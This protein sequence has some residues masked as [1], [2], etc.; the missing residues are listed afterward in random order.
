STNGTGTVRRYE[1]DYRSG[2]LYSV[3][4]TPSDNSTGHPRASHATGENATIGGVAT[5]DV[6]PEHIEIYNIYDT[7]CVCKKPVERRVRST[8]GGVTVSRVSNFTYDP[9]THLLLSRKEPNPEA[10]SGTYPAQIEWTYTYTQAKGTSQDWGAWLPATETTPDGSYTYTYIDW[11]ARTDSVGHGMVP[12]TMTRSITGIRRQDSLNGAVTTS[13]TPVTQTVW[14]NLSNLPGSLPKMGNVNGQVRKTVDGD[15]VETV[16][17]FA[18]DGF[19]T[20]QI[21]GGD[22]KTT[23]ASDAMGQ[24]TSVTSNDGSSVPAVTTVGLVASIGV[25]AEVS[26]TSGGLTRH[27]V[28]LYDRWGHLSVVRRNNLASNGSKPNEYPQSGNTAR[29]WIELQAVYHHTKLMEVYEDRLPLNAAAGTGQFLVTSYNYGADGRLA[30]VVHPN[31]STTTYTFDGYGTLYRSVTTDP[32]GLQSVN[33]PKTFVNQFLEVTGSYQYDGTAHLWTL[34]TRNA[35]GAIIEIQEP[36]T[37][38]PAGYTGSTGGATH[39]FEID[40]LG[41]P[42]VAK[43]WS[44]ATKTTLLESREMR[45]DQLGRQI[46]QRDQVL[47]FGSG[48]RDVAWTYVDGKASQLLSKVGTGVS[49]TTYSYYSATGFLQEVRDG[50]S[51][52]NTAT[53][54]YQNKTPFLASVVRTDLDP[55]S[56]SGTRVTT[57]DYAVDPFGRF[58]TVTQLGD[59]TTVPNN[60]VYSYAYNSL[61]LVDSYTGPGGR[62]QKFLPDALGRV[63]QHVRVGAGNDYIDNRASFE[64]SGASDG[65]TKVTRKDGLGNETVTHNDFAGRPFIVQNPGGSEVPSSSAKYK[66]MCLFAEY[67]GASRL[68]ALYDGDQGKTLFWRDGQ[69]RMIQRQLDGYADNV[70][71]L[72][73]TKDV[74]KRD[75]I[76]R[77]VENGYWGAANNGVPQGLEQFDTDSLGRVHQARFLSAFAPSH[78]L[79]VSSTFSD[80]NPYRETLSYG[81]SLSLE[82][83]NMSFGHDAIGRLTEVQWNKAPGAS[84]AARVLAQYSWAGGLRR[85]RTVRYGST[86]YPQGVSTFS[87]DPLGRLTMIR[88][89]VYTDATTWTTKS[90]FEYAYDEASNLTKEI[91]TKVGGAVGDRF[92]YDAYDRLTQGWMG[93]DAT[94]M[95]NTAN[96]TG[97][98]A[99]HMHEELTYGLDNANNRYSSSTQTGSDPSV[100]D[101]TIEAGTNRYD[102][103]T[104]PG[105]TTDPILTYDKRGNLTYDGRLVYKY[106]FLNRLQEVWRVLPAG[107]PAGDG[108]KFAE[109]QP[110]SLDQAREDVKVDIPDIYSRLAREHTDPVFRAR[111]RATISGGVV[112][113]TPTPGGGGRSFSLPV[114]GQLELVAVYVYDAFNRR[115]MSALVDPQFSETQIHAWDGWRQVS[116]HKLELV[117]GSWQATPTKQFVWGSTLDE[118]V[119]YRR[120]NG[121]SWENYYLLHGGQD[122][123]AK[124]V[125]TSGVVVEQYEYDPY[126]RVSV[127]VGSSTH[128]VASSSYGLPFLWKS[129]RLDEITGLLQM[130]NRYYSTELGRFLTRDPLG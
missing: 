79:T 23:Y 78:T 71:A 92:A 82:G 77:I 14:R 113:I 4:I 15:G 81:G 74:I 12:R 117:N 80:G 107:D 61:G 38:A 41:R 48:T 8:R 119:A 95:G 1:F 70:I 49:A 22:I 116:Q 45:H 111:L 43:T 21:F 69:G 72:F 102:K 63:V 67:D 106:D 2:R 33:S 50:F 24:V 124:L 88:D 18:T 29:D 20:A 30:S 90:Q 11:L 91:Y 60:Q 83:A 42:T 112:R 84:G 109:I 105:A 58:L 16:F 52:G 98:D 3:F 127:Y 59:S 66:P 26:S 96:P 93:V 56:T 17:E 55:V 37:A 126:G 123:A 31:G 53:Y 28:G 57:T 64:D 32:T 99:S 36:A 110:G 54:Y 9:L 51:T 87:F 128:P 40:M 7:T 94:T 10:G 115:T 39:T 130:R 104:V 46:W 75:A 5:T 122:T 114:T 13:S 35:A 34:V 100:T 76:G 65:R 62:V 86:D 19:V 89:N 120:L 108:E 121:S 44:D 85:Q 97:F 118:L 103:V 68:S 47:G 101:Y 129:I 6:E 125:N 73:N 25:P 27:A